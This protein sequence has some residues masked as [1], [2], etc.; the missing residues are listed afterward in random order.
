MDEKKYHVHSLG[1]VAE[2]KRE[3][4]REA[5]EA[6]RILAEKLKAEAHAAVAPIRSPEAEQPLLEYVAG[7]WAEDSEYLREKA[8]VEKKPVSYHHALTNRQMVKNKLA[9]FPGF[10]GVTLSGLTKP[11]IR[12]WKIWLAWQGYSGRTINGAMA[13]LRVPVRR[14]FG[15]DLIPFD[16]FVGVPR[17]PHQEKLRGILR[18]A[19]IKKLLE[20]PVT[21]PRSRL[22]VY[23]ALYCSMRMGEVRGLQWGDIAD[24]VIHICHNW[25][26]IE[27]LKGCKQ[28]SEGYVPMPRIVADLVNEVH[29]KA[30]L[31]GPGDFVMAQR[32]YHPVSR[33]FLWKALRTE[34]ASIGIM[35]E[36]RK[37]RNIV[38]HSLRHSFVTACRV[39]G[40]TDFETMTLS[41]H[42]DVK[43]LHR[44]THGQEAINLTE[45]RAKIEGGFGGGEAARI[46]VPKGGVRF[47][48]P[49]AT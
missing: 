17:A 49:V 22:A 12:Q 24:G 27:G 40:L 9:P 30:P 37:K 48:V 18:P 33:E 26:E 35:E 10:Q 41:R 45:M 29:A 20:T 23:L 4:R 11:L 32:P 5:E 46:K 8:L 1:I 42:H 14:A 2:G 44:Y 28:G 47:G 6:A 34:L 19:E 38:Y 39:A 36:E 7:F 16:P 15:D 21:D 43:M 25:Q 13:A 31:T 3:R